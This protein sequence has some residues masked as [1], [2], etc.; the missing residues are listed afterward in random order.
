[1]RILKNER[2]FIGGE[3]WKS[4]SFA[5][6]QLR[7]KYWKKN[8]NER[9]KMLEIQGL[10]LTRMVINLAERELETMRQLRRGERTDLLCEN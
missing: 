2:A 6:D 10:R 7:R 3:L 9:F 8:V 4:V 5:I 1:M